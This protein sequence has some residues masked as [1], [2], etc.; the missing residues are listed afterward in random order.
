MRLMFIMR[1]LSEVLHSLIFYYL[2][3]LNS[4]IRGLTNFLQN[5]NFYLIAIPIS[6]IILN[7]IVRTFWARRTVFL[8]TS[9]TYMQ[10]IPL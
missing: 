6:N 5:Q 9:V 1:H 4:A 3:N 8:K 2:N 7:F 10:H